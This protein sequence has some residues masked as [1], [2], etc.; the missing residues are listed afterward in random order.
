MPGE[1][2]QAG[3]TEPVDKFAKHRQGHESLYAAPGFSRRLIDQAQKK[4]HTDTLAN[5]DLER[6]PF[7]PNSQES[8][9]RAKAATLRGFYNIII[10]INSDIKRVQE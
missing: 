7:H 2:K 9:A 6:N 10:R 3:E 8:R 5:Y 1:E 4:S